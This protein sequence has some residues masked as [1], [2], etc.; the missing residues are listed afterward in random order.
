[1]MPRI[2]EVKNGKAEP[3]RCGVC[4]YCRQTKV[5]TA[6]IDFELVGFN[7]RELNVILKGEI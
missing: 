2:L 4:E 7:N 1:M 6:P 3:E 5:L